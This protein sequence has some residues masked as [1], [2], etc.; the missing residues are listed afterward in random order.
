MVVLQ[1]EV[2]ALRDES[3]DLTLHDRVPSVA[4]P[5]LG[6]HMEQRQLIVRPVK[7]WVKVVPVEEDLVN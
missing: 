7:V 3:L 4:L 1:C 6:D 2:A 5:V